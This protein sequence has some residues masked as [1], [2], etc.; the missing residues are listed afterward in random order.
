MFDVLSSSPQAYFIVFGLALG[1]AV[2]PALPSEAALITAGLL[3]VDGELS[4]LWVIVAGALGAFC[5]DSISYGLGRFVGRPFQERFLSGE[6]ATRALAWARGQLDERGGMVLLVA[7]YVPGGRTSVTFTCGITHFP[8]ARFAAFDG[9]A[10]ATWA[11][12]A[13]VLGYFG[14]RFFRDREWLALLIAFSVA[15]LLALAVEAVRRLR[16]R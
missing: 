15:G 6:R 2:I 3:C 4:L 9:V 14:G 16:N 12:Y 10:A 5:G 7:R 11:V 13:S 8:Y 1:D